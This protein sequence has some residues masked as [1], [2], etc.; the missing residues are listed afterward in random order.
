VLKSELYL[1]AW[2]RVIHNESLASAKENWFLHSRNGRYFA[3]VSPRWSGKFDILDVIVYGSKKHKGQ[4]T[5]TIHSSLL[6][7]KFSRSKL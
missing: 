2:N 7:Y 5:A 4:I 3:K 1:V 6:K